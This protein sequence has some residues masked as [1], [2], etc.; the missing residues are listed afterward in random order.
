M[1]HG[2]PKAPRSY[3]LVNE[4]GKFVDKTAEIAPALAETGMV[5]SAIWA[6]LNGDKKAELVIA[7]EWMPIKVYEYTSGKLKK[8]QKNMDWKIRKDGGINWLQMIS[9][10]MVIWISLQVTLEKIISLKQAVEK[11]FEV[12]A[13]D[14]DDNGTNDIFLQNIR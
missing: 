5:N 13:K 1:P 9:M 2:Y 4:K 14:F 12:Y 3:L 10:E 7:G 6:D 8:C 11:P